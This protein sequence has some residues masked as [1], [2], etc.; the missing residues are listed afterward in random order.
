MHHL[1]L[2]M[3]RGTRHFNKQI[4]DHTWD[5]ASYW[6]ILMVTT[7][8]TAPAVVWTRRNVCFRTTTG[9]VIQPNRSDSRINVSKGHSIVPVC[10]HQPENFVGQIFTIM[11]CPLI[12]HV[13]KTACTSQ[14]HALFHQHC[15]NIDNSWY[16][17]FSYEMWQMVRD[18]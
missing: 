10:N 5:R 16:E 6:D 3:M 11:H 2:L 14:L 4:T 12:H 1:A 18:H 17:K 13:S 8:V 15:F 7:I 9:N